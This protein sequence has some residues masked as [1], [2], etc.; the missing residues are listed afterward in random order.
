MKL[1][2]P[3][4]LL[5]LRSVAGKGLLVQNAN[6]ARGDPFDIE[7]STYT[8]LNCLA[9]PVISSLIASLRFD[10]ALNVDVTGFQTNLV[11]GMHTINSS[12]P[13]LGDG[14]LAS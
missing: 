6:P 12:P 9:S 5:E 13:S 14:Q 7:R 1:W 4:W 2:F 3:S 10:G 8:N 11:P